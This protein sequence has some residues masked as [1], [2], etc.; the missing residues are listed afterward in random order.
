M[1]ALSLTVAV[2]ILAQPL[3]IA[4]LLARRALVKSTYARSGRR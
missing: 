3:M 4:G 2:A 1:T